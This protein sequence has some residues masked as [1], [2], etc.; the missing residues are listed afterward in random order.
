ML[1]VPLGTDIS[2]GHKDNQLTESQ[3]RSGWKLLFDGKSTTGWRNYRK[4]KIGSGLGGAG[5]CV[6]PC[7]WRSRRHHHHEKYKHFELSLE[8]K[9]SKGGNSGIMFHVTEELRAPWQTGPE[10]QVQ[11]NVDGHDPQKSGW[12]T[13][14]T[15]PSS[16]TGPSV[17]RSRSDTRVRMS[18]MRPGRQASGIMSI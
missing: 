16:P 9:I 1:L 6:D 5:R 13:S 11:D 18:T 15:S 2:A 17:S 4:P 8:Y 7:R 3:R 12:L 14:S 10:I